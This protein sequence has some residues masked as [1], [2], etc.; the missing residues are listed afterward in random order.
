MER[1][2]RFNPNKRMQISE[3][4]IVKC[5]RF[6][7]SGRHLFVYLSNSLTEWYWPL[8]NFAGYSDRRFVSSVLGLRSRYGCAKKAK[9]GKREPRENLHCACVP[10]RM[11]NVFH[12]L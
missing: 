3:S 9:R 12:I 4:L 8:Q 1:A 7:R 6:G 2:C 10:L 5:L 11:A